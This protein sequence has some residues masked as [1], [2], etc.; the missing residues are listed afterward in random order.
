MAVREGFEPSVLLQ[1]QRFSRPA[2]STTPAPHLW[3]F[4]PIF[5]NYVVAYY[6]KIITKE[7]FADNR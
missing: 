7:L 1:V 5:Y 2:R 4:K 3:L 6:I